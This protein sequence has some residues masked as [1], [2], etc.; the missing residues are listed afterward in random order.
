MSI[1]H[2]G[3]GHISRGGGHSNFFG[4]YVPHELSEVGS[5]ELGS[6]ERL[7]AKMSVFGA[8]I[9]PIREKWA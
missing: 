9:L 2:L 3:S 1:D 7:F 8:E 6:R 5:T 4:G